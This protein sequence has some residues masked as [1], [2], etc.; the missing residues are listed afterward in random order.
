MMGVENKSTYL[1]QTPLPLESP[2]PG[3]EAL[4]PSSGGWNMDVLPYPTYEFGGD[5]REVRA[6]RV[7]TV[8]REKKLQ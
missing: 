8:G 2:S 4:Q 3:L 6:S 1:A 5:F 7:E